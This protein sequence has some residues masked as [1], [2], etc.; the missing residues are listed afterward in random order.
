MI[1]RFKIQSIASDSKFT[2]E[3]DVESNQTLFDL[4]KCIQEELEYNEVFDAIFYVSNAQWKKETES[5]VLCGGKSSKLMDMV[6]LGQLLQRKLLYFI[7]EYDVVLHRYLTV[8]LID[9]VE[10]LPR[11]HYPYLVK[12]DGTI[13]SQSLKK[14]DDAFFSFDAGMPE[15]SGNGFS[16]EGGDFEE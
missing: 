15:I 9:M 4:H 11:I 6:T 5:Y 10:A 1:Y 3:I 13:P 12:M 7:Y 8:E 16:S 2:M 14:T